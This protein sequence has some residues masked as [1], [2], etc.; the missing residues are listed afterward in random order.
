M[1]CFQYFVAIDN[2]WKIYNHIFD[3]NISRSNSAHSI[4]YHGCVSKNLPLS[5]VDLKVIIWIPDWSHSL[6]YSSEGSS[7]S[8]YNFLDVPALLAFRLLFA[9]VVLEWS[10]IIFLFLFASFSRFFSCLAA[11]SSAFFSFFA[12]SLS[13]LF[14]K[15]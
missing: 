8:S 1:P 15:R 12:R 6:I 9:R 13:S 5:S 7:S 11:F 4:S 3:R 10:G 2:I 14:A